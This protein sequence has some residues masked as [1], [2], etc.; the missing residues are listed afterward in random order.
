M[1]ISIKDVVAITGTPGLFRI[2]KSD[3]RS[4]IVESIDALKKRR[5][6]PG[7]M[8][9][10]KLV[11]VSFYTTEDSEPLVNILLAAK[12]KY[13]GDLPVSK[14]SSNAELMDFLKSVLP[15]Y[16]TEKVYPSN[17]KKLVGWFNIIQKNEIDLTIEEEEEQKEGSPKEEGKPKKETSKKAEASAMEEEK[18]DSQKAPAKKS[19][20]SK[21]AED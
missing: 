8:M 15:N 19:T 16:D 12:E 11:D 1:S 6:V 14:K 2:V 5:M 13:D 20:N 17:V 9:V 7:T 3:D 10:L 21:K 4:L 18:I